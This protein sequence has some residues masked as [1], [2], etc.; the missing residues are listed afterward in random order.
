MLK[1]MTVILLSKTQTGTDGFE[2]PIYSYGTGTEISNVLVGE[3]TPEE[4]VDELNLSGRKIQYIL[5]IPKGDTH[6]WEDQ[7]VE[8]FG[9][10]WRTVGITVE[11]IEA[12]IPLQWHKKVRVERYE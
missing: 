3:P 10:R 9:K 5:G 7:I 11:G 1:G 12:N 2:Q 6:D 4:R 8:F